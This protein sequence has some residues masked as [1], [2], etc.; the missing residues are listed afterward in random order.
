VTPA[1]PDAVIRTPFVGRRD[2]LDHLGAAV[3]AARLGRFAGVL[4]GGPAGIGKSRLI[5]QVVASEVAAGHVLHV[6]GQALVDGRGASP[7]E[8]ARPLVELAGVDLSGT[9]GTSSTAS[10]DEQAR[11]F[12]DVGRGLERAA[13]ERGPLLITL[14]D[15]HWADVTSLE[16]L[17][18][19][20]HRLAASPVAV[21]ATHRDGADTTA[22]L[23][24]LLVALSR[25]PGITRIALDPL[26]LD[27]LSELAELRLG[28][29]LE[30]GTVEAVA[31]RSGGI[32]LFVE[33]LLDEHGRAGTPHLPASLRELFLATLDT[34]DDAARELVDVVAVAGGEIGHALLA[35][36]ADVADHELEKRIDAILD[37][38][39]LVLLPDTSGY[40]FRHD[41]LR[42][43]VEA[44]LRPA[45]R[46]RLHGDIARVL[47][48]RPDLVTH[49]RSASADLAVHLLASG[50]VAGG[51]AATLAAAAEADAAHAYAEALAHRL[52]LLEL[53]PSMP[54][55]TH[56]R[57]PLLLSAASSAAHAAEHAQA[58]ELF[59]QAIELVPDPLQRLPLLGERL[60]EQYLANDPAG[61]G[62]TARQALAELP[63]DAP[64]LTR[65]RVLSMTAFAFAD[66]TVPGT[67]L[68]ATAEAVHIARAEGDRPSLMLALTSHGLA[69]AVE[70]DLPAAGAVFDEAE[71]LAEDE[72]DPRI[73][74][75]PRLYR[76]LM[77]HDP[78]T[79]LRLGLEGIAR[80]DRLG[81]DRGVSK[82]MRAVVSD[83]LLATGRWEEARTVIEDGLAW[84]ARDFAGMLL[85]LNRAAMLLARGEAEAAEE[86]LGAVLAQFPEGHPRASL[87]AS[88]LAWWKG[89]LIASAAHAGAGL[90]LAVVAARANE[91]PQ[92]TQQL[93]RA[94]PGDAPAE[95]QQPLQ[96]AM[97]LLA[98]RS[99]S[100][101]TAAWL[102]TCQAEMSGE[103]AAWDDA[104][105]RWLAVG[106]R[107]SAAYAAWR[108]GDAH[109]AVGDVAPARDAWRQAETIGR[110]LGMEPMLRALMGPAA[111]SADAS[112]RWTLPDAVDLGLTAREAE[113]L[114]YVAEGWS[115]KRIA[116]ELVISPRTVGI[117]VSNVL[118]K[119]G[120]STRGEAAALLRRLSA[121]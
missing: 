94:L 37:A 27:D 55:G 101:V 5:E 71:L 46:R 100:P 49:G 6:A 62:R 75:R 45:A 28:R 8:V 95:H 42:E 40:R 81:G 105:Q 13:A 54:D 70:G 99:G 32:T 67:P 85:Q 110:E 114:G 92:L 38:G 97:A 48:A 88:E 59:G 57:L 9:P 25:D 112:S 106:H 103:A 53:L 98:S 109:D 80:A 87:V 10:A 79:E 119:L 77:G 107:P 90:R 23:R 68:E 102:A 31:A 34:L 44:A 115:N 104:L 72:T 22:A 41:L 84:G 36:V 12:Q 2:A 52:A 16:L 17:T 29:P 18:Y 73:A 39:I 19:L 89:D 118:H 66:P 61:A 74:L 108:A 15:L 78:D 21:L 11:L 58:A 51:F 43:T 93:A 30:R 121:G 3:A 4:V 96:M 50:D 117:H 91:V 7:L 63:D 64:R 60:G 24:A 120:V 116:D 26:P 82:Q 56:E 20:A 1:R 86:D 14:E 76:I 111:R 47:G 83:T 35:A 69:L 33:E 113:V 65:S